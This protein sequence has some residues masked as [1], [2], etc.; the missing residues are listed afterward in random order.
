M[1]AEVEAPFRTFRVFI[2]GFFVVS[3]S[4]ASLVAT[5][6][7]IGALGHAPSA[8]PLDECLQTLAIDV[9]AGSKG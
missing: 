8:K 2:V 3:A 9:G 1:R 5:S 7:L 6:Q 4:V